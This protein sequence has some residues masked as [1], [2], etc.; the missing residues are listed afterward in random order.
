MQSNPVFIGISR[1]E[2]NVRPAA[3]FFMKCSLESLE[4][5]ELYNSAQ[6]GYESTQ[7]YTVP[8]VSIKIF[9][10]S[11]HPCTKTEMHLNYDR[12]REVNLI[13]IL[14]SQGRTKNCQTFERSWALQNEARSP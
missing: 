9:F 12:A 4:I 10:L 7:I 1:R 8:L 11:M 2:L 3:F 14:N 13:K 6:D 5:Q